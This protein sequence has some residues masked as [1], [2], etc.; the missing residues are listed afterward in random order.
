MSYSSQNENIFKV[1][2][3]YL[4]S[5]PMG[6]LLEGE[7]GSD[8]I[9]VPLKRTIMRTNGYGREC[10]LSVTNDSLEVAFTKTDKSNSNLKLPIELLAYCGALRQL[11]NG[12]IRTREFETLDKFPAN[13][14]EASPP[15]FVTI[16]R[17]LDNENTL[18]CHSFVIKQDDDAMELVKLVMEMYYN[19]IR[20]NDSEDEND[21]TNND[22]NFKTNL[23]KNFSSS[24]L[25][26]ELELENITNGSKN[27]DNIFKNST[28]HMN[29]LFD[30]YQKIPQI[31]NGIFFFFYKIKIF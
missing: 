13:N 3:M 24:S 18:Y 12:Q 14:D 6:E 8:V 27:N 29:D 31:S 25:S 7:S 23:N 5:E 4:G 17:S 21:T 26:L 1:K 20:L 15:L 16:F 22:K 28:Q 9:Q 19:L 11:P 2:S 10:L 30:I